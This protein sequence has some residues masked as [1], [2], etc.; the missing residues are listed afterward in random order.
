MIAYAHTSTHPDGSPKPRE[1]WQPLH[2][3]DPAQPGHLE[4]VAALA[5][6]FASTFALA[7]T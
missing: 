1:A 6:E 5:E 2:T 3:G 4:A 7:S